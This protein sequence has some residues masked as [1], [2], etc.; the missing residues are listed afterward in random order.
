MKAIAWTAFGRPEVLQLKD[1]PTPSPKKGEVLIKVF[2]STVTAGDARLR[3][4][5]VPAGFKLLSRLAFGF[6]KP[7][8]A[9]P[10]MELSGEIVAVGENVNQF[11]VGDA[12]YGS[13]GMKLGAHAEYVCLTEKA[14]LVKKPDNLN[15]EQ[16]VAII[17]GGL[18]ALHFLRD[19]A[20][21]QQGQKVLINGAAG[22]VGT[23]AV[24]LAKFFGAEVTGVCSTAN[25]PLVQA[26]GAHHLIDYSQEDMTTHGA[27]YDII[28]DTVGNLHWAKC[29]PMLAKD[30]KLILINASL[31]TQLSSLI[32]K[33]LICGVADE[34]KG[35]LNYLRERAE[36]NDIKPV[37]DKTYPLSQIAEAHHHVDSGHKKGNVVITIGDSLPRT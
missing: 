12:V 7:K 26:L 36:A 22:A 13:T 34:S 4:L 6:S 9:I 5:R 25:L 28:L 29:E 10:G 27:C 35:G 8:R 30:G 33:R 3:A 17:F 1:F 21:I 11:Q 19:C 23:A 2:A 31:K 14:A 15:H 16:A 18:T 24:Q 20:N 32:N 37:I